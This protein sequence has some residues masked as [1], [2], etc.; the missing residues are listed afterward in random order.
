MCRHLLSLR[1]WVQGGREECKTG[2]LR[3]KVSCLGQKAACCC[4]WV[5]GWLVP[6]VSLLHLWSI[7]TNCCYCRVP[8]EVSNTDLLSC[9]SVAPPALERR[10]G[11]SKYAG[12]KVLEM[13]MS[14]MGGRTCILQTSSSKCGAGAWSAEML[15]LSSGASHWG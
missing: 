11:K 3:K 8:L 4:C 6:G 12:E 1:I 13:L 15:A 7:P 14:G 9:C 10:G 5:K 2:S